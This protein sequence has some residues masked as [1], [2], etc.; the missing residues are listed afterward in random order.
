[1]A[2]GIRNFGMKKGAS[3]EMVKVHFLIISANDVTE[4]WHFQIIT[5]EIA[6]LADYPDKI[7]CAAIL[8]NLM[9]IWNAQSIDSYSEIS[10]GEMSHWK[11]NRR[12]VIDTL[13]NCNNLKG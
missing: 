4:M 3:Y 11:F 8:G 1:M 12:T 13:R 7:R 2:A 10:F 5:C 6:D 9:I